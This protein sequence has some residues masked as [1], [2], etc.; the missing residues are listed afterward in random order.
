MMD[1]RTVILVAFFILF[2]STII[3]YVMFFK[4]GKDSHKEESQIPF[5]NDDLDN[6]E[7]KDQ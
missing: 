7:E 2:I 5:L 3:V 1:S 4:S 6:S